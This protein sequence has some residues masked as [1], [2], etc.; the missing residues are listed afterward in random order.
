MET[1]DK[2]PASNAEIAEVIDLIDELEREGDSDQSLT[3]CRSVAT[4]TRTPQLALHGILRLIEGRYTAD[5][6]LVAGALR[7]IARAHADTRWIQFRCGHHFA[8]IGLIDQGITC[9]ERSVEL[10]PSVKSHQHVGLLYRRKAEFDKGV[11][12]LEAALALAPDNRELRSDLLQLLAMQ[13]DIARFE[14]LAN[15]GGLAQEHLATCHNQ[16]GQ[17][18]LARGDPRRALKCLERAVKLAPDS[19]AFLW[20][21]HLTVYNAYRN[22]KDLSGARAKYLAALETIEERY[23]ALT[24]AEKDFAHRCTEQP[25]NHEVHYQSGDDM[26]VQKPVGLLLHRIMSHAFPRYMTQMPRRHPGNAR[27]LRVGFISSTCFVSSPCQRSFGSWATDL[28]RE[29]FEVFGYTLTYRQDETTNRMAGAV[30]HFVPFGGDVASL[31]QRIVADEPDV[32][33][34][35]DVGMDPLVQQLAPLR[36]APVQCSGAGHPVT[37]G[38]PNVDYFLGSDLM[39]TDN[40]Q[41]NYTETLVRLPNLGISPASDALPA[42]QAC[43]PPGALEGRSRAGVIFLCAQDPRRM[44]PGHDYLFARILQGVPDAEIWFIASTR[45]DVT[46]AF[47]RRL[48]RTCESYGVDSDSRCVILPRLASVEFGWVIH[49]VDL[50][51]DTSFWSGCS[52]TFESLHRGTPVMTLPGDSMRGRRS[53]AILRHLG[54]DELVAGTEK[55]YVSLAIRLATDRDFYAARLAEIDG[56]RDRLS[57][58][59]SVLRALEDFLDRSLTGDV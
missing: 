22:E 44:M 28:D 34:Y 31:R 14:A 6:A 58:D 57:G 17:T 2:V 20:S 26:A 42:L 54:L 1:K 51:L 11:R 49:E 10:Q 36:L 5:I 37:T 46:R 39:E 8:E 24:P 52:T 48:S 29:R 35:P 16:L 3:L 23:D 4:L 13:G 53:F 45:E 40:A 56:I 50:V 18:L 30:E 59:E 21:R 7:D 15:E 27:R 9:Y 19:F 33:I 32:L 41:A 38:L 12:H 43:H 25:T 47:R 55:E